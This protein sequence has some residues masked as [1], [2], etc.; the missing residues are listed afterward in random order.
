MTSGTPNRNQNHLTMKAGESKVDRFWHAVQARDTGADGRFVYAV[1][2]TGIYCR[3]SCPSRRPRRDS[4]TF[5]ATPDAAELGGYRECRRCRPRFGVAI[6]P[7]LPNVR[8]ACAFIEA[9]R[10]EPLTLSAIASRVDMSPFHLQRVFTR[11]V[12]I[13]PRAYQDAL[14]AGTFR[15]RLRRGT[16][17]SGAIYE[18]GYGSSSRVYEQKPTGT[19]M[20]PAAYRVGGKGLI[21]S[22]TI[23]DSPLGRLLIAGT[24]LGVCS[25][26][27]GDRDRELEADL[28]MEYPRAVIAKDTRTRSVW[29]RAIL[30]HIAGRAPHIDLPIDVQ[31]TAFQWKVWRYLQSIP[32]G[33]TR[34]YSQVAK[35]I[36]RPSATRAVARACATNRVALLI[37]CHRVVGKD[38]KLTGYRWGTERKRA[39]LDRES[40]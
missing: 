14:R 22:Y 25:V 15:S 40:R 27:L 34:T 6:P 17:L 20:T 7:G 24:P 33:E 37:P 18:S 39:L 13:S 35:D 31:A 5:F 9:H 10:G 11:F 16:P 30:A 21:V 28:R 8:A 23:T 12:G 36:G 19:G 1:R 4:V 38:G 26:K 29:V 2:S 3:P 32:W